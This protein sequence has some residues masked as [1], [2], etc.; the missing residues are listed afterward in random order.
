M[1][2]MGR[3]EGEDASTDKVSDVSSMGAMDSK[4]ETTRMRKEN[5]ATVRV[6]FDDGATLTWSIKP[7]SAAALDRK[8]FV[9][10]LT[11]FLASVRS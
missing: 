11:T 9:D 2:R 5:K 7:G 6:V 3:A 8:L 1:A 10:E 4:K